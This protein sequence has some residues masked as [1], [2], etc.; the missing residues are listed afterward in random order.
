MHEI[1]Y[2]T[3]DLNLSLVRKKLIGENDNYN[4]VVANGL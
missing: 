1:Y 2:F 3:I 4:I